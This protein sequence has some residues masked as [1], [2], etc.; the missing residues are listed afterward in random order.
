M[1]DLT[2][3][4]LAMRLAA[5]TY[6][7]TKDEQNWKCM[8]DNAARLSTLYGELRKLSATSVD[9]ETLDR[10]DKAT[11]EYL[12]AAKLWA[13]GDT[14]L[15]TVILPE[16]SK[17]GETVV[18]T[19]Q[20]DENG[21][22]KASDDAA[23]TVLG[24][25]GTSKTIIIVAQ[26]LGVLVVVVLGYFISKSISKVLGALIGETK[27]LST[28]AVEGKLQTRG[29]P[30]SVSLEFRPIVEN[31]N[32]AMDVFTGFIDHIPSPFMT[33]NKDREILY[34]NDCV[35]TVIGLDKR[36]IEGTKCYEHF[37]TTHCNTPE[38]AC[39]RA[40]EQRCAVTAET[41]A[42]PAGRELEISYVGLPIKDG[43]GKVVG[44]MEFV[45]DLTAVKRAAKVT[46]KVSDFQ[47]QQSRTL[48]QN[49]EKLSAGDFNLA[50]EV[51]EGDADTAAA[52]ESFLQI[53][54][55]VKQVV[56]TLRGMTA[57]AKKLRQA[58]TEG[59]LDVR[60]D[61][62]RYDGEYRQIIHGINETLA[63]F[64]KPIHEIAEVLTR[65]AAKDFTRTVG[66][67]YPGLYGRLRDNVNQVVTNMRT[68]IEQ[69]TETAAQFGEGSRVVA[70][71]SQT[72]AHG[73]QT[74]SA[75]VE[76]MTASV[77]ELTRSI[78][79]VK[80]NAVEADK[81]AKQTNQLAEDGGQA[82]QK[83]VEA[84]DLI[85]TS[86]QQISEIIRVISEIASQ[87]N[88]LALNAA[89]E[90]ARAGEHGMGF[91]VVAD[92]VRK[93][94]ERSNQ[95]AREISTLIKE[96]TRRVQDGADLSEQ[97]GTSLKKIIEGVEITAAKISEIAAAAVQQAANAQEVSKAIAGIAEVTETAAAGSQQMASSSQELGAQA[98][99]LRDLV[100]HFKTGSGHAT[101]AN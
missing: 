63:G 64:E 71:G 101:I 16:L 14:K 13:K 73:A 94:A 84:M 22:W 44:V 2:Q 12:A 23:S 24:I 28:A 72:M 62:A 39:V 43:G 57:D 66:S 61:E 41:T 99:A 19:I 45:T 69:I 7:G 10:A 21:A 51:A 96:S 90:A 76:E 37:K 5:C 59:K 56:E 58:A 6:I 86:S 75:S 81:I 47:S 36:Q 60:A 92:E 38:C 78:D 35:A 30:E 4:T 95:A 20:A 89:I 27:R 34:M 55:A 82:V 1:F 98:S 8:T 79:V 100:S 77:E 91:A 46:A 18:D 87:T 68:A 80:A 11:Q 88:L 52:R 67:Q 49:L 65:L 48:T 54:G 53:A 33:M 3:T 32:A 83:S 74:Q 25:V 17:A 26:I 40:M 93:L 85:R 70:E 31:V 15:R 50:L 29:N 97:T 42:R 9:R